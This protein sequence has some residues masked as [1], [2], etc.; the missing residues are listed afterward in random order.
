MSDT[1]PAACDKLDF[2]INLH[3]PASSFLAD[4]LAGLAKE[5]KTVKAKYFYDENGSKL[6][7]EI[8]KTPEYYITRTELALLKAHSKDFA[9]TLG[10]HVNIIELGS[11]AS[12]KVRTLLN[13]LKA[14]ASYTAID[15]S[16]QF[17]CE[18]ANK[19]GADYPNMKT[20]AICA[21]F[22]SDFPL[23]NILAGA[24]KTL[25]FLPGS[26]LGNFSPKQAGALLAQMR[27]MLG[28]HGFFLLGVDKIKDKNILEA[29]YNDKAGK[30]AAFNFNILKRMK[31]ELGAK[32]NHK[33]FAHHAFYNEEQSRIEMH[34]RATS[35]Q[36]IKI[37]KK[38][39]TF[40][41]NETL[42]TE[43]SW[44]YS[45]QSFTHLAEQAG[46]RLEQSWEDAQGL[47]ALYLLRC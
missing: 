14:P 5:Q 43:S 20:G 12:R 29:A 30:N 40:A 34:L 24:G 19:L 26:T 25:G 22:T 6:F 9:E 23:P 16:F 21:D 7:E 27:R 32:L 46:Y 8:C 35:K 13:C 36:T 33:G 44:K 37:D 47:F 17:L 28:R 11:G 38:T 3:P 15:M 45:E 2:F 4:V 42:H 18:S 31:T 1:I 10:E 41:K 39:F